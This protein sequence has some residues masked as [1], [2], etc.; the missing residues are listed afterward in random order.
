M[1][2]FLRNHIAPLMSEKHALPI[3]NKGA[4]WCLADHLDVGRPS[5]SFL[6]SPLAVFILQRNE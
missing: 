6:K 3:D 1:P 2:P 4:T 5:A